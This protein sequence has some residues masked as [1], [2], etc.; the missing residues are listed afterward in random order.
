MK[1][2][3]INIDAEGVHYRKLNTAVRAALKAGYGK[4]KIKNV[5]G[6]RFIGN[7]LSGA[8]VNIEIE[9]T[10][11]ADMA[12]FM[13]GASVTVRGNVQDACGNT[14]NSGEVAIY[15]HSGDILGHSMRGGRIFV[16]GNV[17]YRVGI[18]MKAYK[19]T[20]PLIVIGGAAGSFLGEYMAGG[21]IIVLGLKDSHPLAGDFTGTGMHGGA[22]YLRGDIDRRTL[23]QEVAVSAPDEGDLKII[24]DAVNAFC[25]HFKFSARKIL[26]K[27]FIKL[28]PYSNRPYG[29]IYAY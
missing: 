25:G 23:G 8:N 3:E 1:N 7:S 28:Y 26:K 4:I 16:R 29:K 21:N 5:C 14:M 13:N 9:G 19:Q 2:K 10:P 27:K 18:H 24:K 15:G 11:G 22:I 20:S 6:Q 17:G 12:A